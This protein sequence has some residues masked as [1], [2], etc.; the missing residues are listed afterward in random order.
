M[1][2]IGDLYGVQKNTLSIIVREFC[3]VVRKYLQLVFVQTPNKSQFRVL[4]SK[5]EQLHIILYI[6]SAI[7]GSHIYVLAPIIDG[8]DYYCRK[9]FHSAILQGNAGPDCMFWNYEFGWARSLHDWTI[10]QVTKIGHACIEGK[11]QLYKLIGDI[12]YLVR[13]WM[14]C[15]FKGGKQRYPGKRQIGILYNLGQGCA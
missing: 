15:L 7:D 12:A 14:Y 2:T 4:A 13:L 6:I 10:F 8:D 1:Q 5:F 11:F 9:S 3:R